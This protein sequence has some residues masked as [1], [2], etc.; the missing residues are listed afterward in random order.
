MQIHIFLL[1]CYSANS[2]EVVW[3]H[4]G[5][6]SVNII[7]KIPSY[8]VLLLLRKW[9]AAFKINTKVTIPSAPHQNTVT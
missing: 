4:L 3:N 5:V 1:F 8:C 7:L 6:S 2:L 9:L